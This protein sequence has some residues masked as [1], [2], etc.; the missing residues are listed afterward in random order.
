MGG[1][2]YCCSGTQFA[3]AL[4]ARRAK[5]LCTALRE[6]HT[7]RSAVRALCALCLCPVAVAVASARSARR[8]VRAE[9]SASHLSCATRRQQQSRRSP[10][11]G[12]LAEPRGSA[13]R[14]FCADDSHR[15]RPTD[16]LGADG[17]RRAGG[18]IKQ[19]V[20]AGLGAGP[21]WLS[22][23]AKHTHTANWLLHQRHASRAATLHRRGAS[24]RPELLRLRLRL[25]LARIGYLPSAARHLS[26]G[27][28][29]ARAG[30][31]RLTLGCLFDGC[32]SCWCAELV[33]LRVSCFG[34]LLLAAWCCSRGLAPAHALCDAGS[35]CRWAPSESGGR[36][37]PGLVAADRSASGRS[38]LWSLITRSGLPLRIVAAT[39]HLSECEGGSEFGF[40]FEIGFGFGFGSSSRR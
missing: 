38:T 23:G 16:R 13:G 21:L 18:S 5:R 7:H 14:A 36:G 27:A 24:G 1:D 17:A 32:C 10:W 26:R 4:K 34:C 20:R 25:R 19:S 29:S 39:L 11:R 22:A 12:R 30:R 6:W 31:R 9:A 40:G 37:A 3:S 28:G 15:A 35:P 8:F 33:N 2:R